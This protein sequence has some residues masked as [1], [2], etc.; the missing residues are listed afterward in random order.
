MIYL[1]LS[2]GLGNQLYQLAAAALLSQCRQTPVTVFTDALQRYNS[3]RDPDSIQLLMDQQWLHVA[4]TAEMR[5]H[6]WLSVSARA[7]RLLPGLGVNDKTF[8]Q[9]SKAAGSQWPLFADGYFQHGWTQDTFARA[10]SAMHVRP[11]A[12]RAAERLMMDEIAVHIRGGD[13][14]KLP[15]FQVV[16]APFYID[17]VRQSLAQGFTRF[18]VITDDPTYAAKV[19]NAIKGHCPDATFRMLERGANALE[20]FDTLRSAPGRIMGNSTFAWWAT[21]FGRPTAPTWSPPMFTTDT[22]RDFFLPN[23]RQIACASE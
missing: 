13:F 16:H 19:C 3:P 6:R 15:R 12:A 21:A 4:S 23:E 5:I 20:D 11:I 1:R 10:I 2:G 17:A 14:L 9:R 22:P 8:W 18:A 7:G